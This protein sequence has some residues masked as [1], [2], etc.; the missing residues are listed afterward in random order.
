MEGKEGKTE[1][2]K[3][4]TIYVGTIGITGLSRP[5]YKSS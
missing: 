4:L 3:K 1:S 5:H 2:G